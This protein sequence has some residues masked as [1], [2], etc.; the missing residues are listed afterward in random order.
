MTSQPLK[1]LLVDDDRD[2]Y[3]I[4][5]DLISDIESTRYAL[6]WVADFEGAME[7]LRR[8][9]H[10]VCLVDYRLGAR[11]GLEVIEQAHREGLTMPMILLTGQSEHTVDLKAMQA[12]A[13]DF[14]VKGQL[15][16]IFL[17]RSI[18]YAIE[19]SRAEAEI[20][21][22]AAFARFNPNPVMEF[23][24][25]ATLAYFND[26]ARHMASSLGCDSPSA[27][28]PRETAEVVRECLASGQSRLQLQTFVGQRTLSWSFF[29][30][31]GSNVVHCYA[32]DL[33]ERL[34]LESQLRHAQKME[35]VGQLAAGVA[36][37][38]NNIL[39]II[40]GHASMLHDS[41]SGNSPSVRPLREIRDAAERAG[42]L[43]RQ[44]LMFSR[45][46]ILQ[47]RP[48]DLSAVVES[49]AGMLRRTLGEHIR[50]HV[51]STGS[52][53]LIHAD[54]VMIEQMLMNL[55]VNARD[56][57]PN[58]GLLVISTRLAQVTPEAARRNA[59]ARP[60][61]FLCLTVADSGCGMGPDTVSR[62]FEPF[63]TTKEVGKGTGLGLATVYG[64]MKQHK[65]WIEVES[66]PGRGTSFH[67]FLP[68]GQRQGEAALPGNT[69]S[70]SSGP[71][72]GSETI[73]VVEDEPA[74]RELVV[75]ILQ[76]HGY[77][78]LSADC[79]SQALDVWS[80]HSSEI[81]LVVTDMVMPGMMGREL[82]ERLQREDP[83]I[84][85]IYTS[86][87]SPGMAG[88]DLALLEGFNFLPKPY[89]PSKLAQLVREC[90]DGT[91]G[92]S[93]KLA[94][95]SAQS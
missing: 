57:M 51:K 68:T 61:E 65:G 44:L 43:I 32:T 26:A 29:P 5:R 37:D 64:A 62:I 50:L 25:S 89:P 9:E 30:I 79:G 4:T 38:F 41:Q 56:A 59:E 91:Q 63:F 73:L 58:G 20:Q 76:C 18:R 53:P 80:R 7:A 78:V 88:K 45:K 42:N 34:T 47:P 10:Q 46:Q 21:K 1:V 2:D 12:G 3:L 70:S 19:R 27:L 90:L 55:A 87:Y 85:I 28:L 94:V 31:P 11:S 69:S 35:A 22:L 66:A 14:L 81:A 82:A 16:S 54:P 72:E 17:E 83:R 23:S 8:R 48:L 13:A 93:A 92:R 36:H 39:T 40:Q 95:P 24:A 60:G 15:N 6:D 67:L 33:T 74:L 49:V 52:L 75:E 84:K 86:G 77:N 71:K